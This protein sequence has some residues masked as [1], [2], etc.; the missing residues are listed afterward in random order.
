MVSNTIKSRSSTEWLSSF[1]ACILLL[2][3]VI[4]STSSDIHNQI[5]RV[6]EH[7]WA[8]YYKLRVDPVIPSCDPQLNVEAAVL[9]RLAESGEEDDERTHQG[10]EG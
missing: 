5:L 1:P 8:G 10:A 9:E 7:Y 2:L 3:V 4:F 6:G